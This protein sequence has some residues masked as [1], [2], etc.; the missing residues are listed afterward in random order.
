VK[1]VRDEIDSA[2]S[3]PM[4][5]IASE[6]WCPVLSYIVLNPELMSP[7]VWHRAGRFLGH[8]AGWPFIP[9]RYGVL[10]TLI[11]DEDKI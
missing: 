11:E 6:H 7:D 3:D 8:G 10:F 4:G 5:A 1:Q 9:V 2:H